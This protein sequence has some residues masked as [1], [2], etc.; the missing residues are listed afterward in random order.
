MA[1]CLYM[2]V[3]YASIFAFSLS[4]AGLSCAWEP[5][6]VLGTS[7]HTERERERV[8]RRIRR[9][10]VVCIAVAPTS[11]AEFF[12]AANLLT[13]SSLTPEGLKIVKKMSKKS[14]LMKMWETGEE[15]PR[16]EEHVRRQRHPS[17]RPQ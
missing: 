17:Q 9:S 13:M 5:L 10:H 11:I 3:E 14:K 15:M 7:T 6:V 12:C 1:L 8:S 4:F 16:S 2:H